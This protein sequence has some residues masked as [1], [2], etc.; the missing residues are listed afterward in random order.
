M[1]KSVRYPGLSADPSHPIA[2]SQMHN[3]GFIISFDLGSAV[4]ADQF[5][6]SAPLIF[7]ATSFGGVHTMAERRARWGTDDV[8]EGLVRLSVGCEHID[9]LIDNIKKAL[10][11][12]SK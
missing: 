3:F 7:E 5:L 2:R 10:G 4:A 9:D 11:Q 6:Q 8:P 1:V 12:L